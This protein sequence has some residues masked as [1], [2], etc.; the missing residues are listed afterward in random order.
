MRKTA[1]SWLRAV[2]SDVSWAAS[3]SPT[4]LSF[5]LQQDLV[6]IHVV[7]FH[8]PV[9]WKELQLW[10]CNKCKLVNW[11]QV[12]KI[13]LHFI[14]E[15]RI[16]LELHILITF[17]TTWRNKGERTWDGKFK[18]NWAGVTRPTLPTQNTEAPFSRTLSSELFFM[19]TDWPS[20]WT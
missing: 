16:Y 10:H 7:V 9:S 3:D 12:N 18:R 20:H 19:N 14:S 6:F 17:L 11:W 5:L 13:P 2:F 4:H 15:K 8:F 1:I